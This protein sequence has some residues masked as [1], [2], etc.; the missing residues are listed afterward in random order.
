MFFERKPVGETA[1]FH[2]E[3]KRKIE[4]DLGKAH[5]KKYLALYSKLTL[6]ISKETM[7]WTNELHPDYL[8]QVNGPRFSLSRLRNL[9][10]ISV[11][12]NYFKANAKGHDLHVIYYGD[13][14]HGLLQ[15]LTAVFAEKINAE[16][17]INN[18]NVSAVV[19]DKIIQY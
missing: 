2:I 9:N 6:E 11:I 1:Q 5:S 19:A 17:N 13:D 14:N 7:A 3:L 10:R 8:K 4:R 16:W 15:N 18:M 12:R